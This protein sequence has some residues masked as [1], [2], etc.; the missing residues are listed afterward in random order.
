MSKQTELDLR[1]ASRSQTCGS[2]KIVFP[3]KSAARL[4][5]RRKSFAG[6]RPYRCPECAE[7]H[8]GHL[9]AAVR[10]GARTADEHYRVS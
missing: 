6:Q 8:V 1:H 10:M 2:R 9:P 5:L 7:I 3:S 4:F